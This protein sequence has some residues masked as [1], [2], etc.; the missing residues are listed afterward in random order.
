MTH[1]RDGKGGRALF[2]LAFSLVLSTSAAGQ[3]TQSFWG[4]V[5][6]LTAE[7]GFWD[8]PTKWDSGTLPL[9]QSLV[10]IKP[11]LELDDIV[12]TYRNTF[13]PGAKWES[14]EVAGAPGSSLTLA[15]YQTDFQ[16]R[17][18]WID[19]ATVDQ[20]AVDVNISE[21]V[22]D[23]TATFG[24]RYILRSGTLMTPID[25]QGHANGLRIDPSHDGG[26]VFD[27]RGGIADLPAF[28]VGGGGLYAQSGGLLSAPRLSI[29][30]NGEVELTGGR[31]NLYSELALY[32]GTAD[33]APDATDEALL[34]IS[35]DA[36]LNARF[37]SPKDDVLVG[38]DT[39]GRI[40]Q[41][42]NDSR[43]NY[44]ELRVGHTAAGSYLLSSGE[45]SAYA[46][47]V[48]SAA[49]GSITQTGGVFNVEEETSDPLFGAGLLALGDSVNGGP[50]NITGAYDLQGG[51]LNTVTTTVGRNTAGVFD[52]H[53]GTFHNTNA[54][55]I[56]NNSILNRP[57]SDG[58]YNLHGGT[59]VAGQTT[60]GRDGLGRFNHVNGAHS[61]LGELTIRG[62]YDFDD[63]N[64]NTTDTMLFDG[65]FNHHGGTHLVFDFLWADGRYTQTGGLL[66][67]AR[68]S[69]GEVDSGRFDQQGGTHEVIGELIVGNLLNGDGEYQLKPNA[70][71]KSD[72]L[73]V[74][75]DGTGLFHQTGGTHSTV[76]LVVGAMRDG[77]GAYTFDGGDLNVT[78]DADVGSNGTGVFNQN[79]DGVSISNHL[80]LGRNPGGEGTYNLSAGNL[81]VENLSVGVDGTGAFTAENGTQ[82]TVNQTLGVATNPNSAGTLTV[83]NV[84]L[85]TH[86]AHIAGRA[87]FGPTSA[88][89]VDA[90]IT[91]T[92][93]LNG[94]EPVGDRPGVLELDYGR[95][96]TKEVI[97]GDTD[98]GRLEN[99]FATHVSTGPIT[100]GKAAG[101]FGRYQLSFGSLT[102]PGTT[103]GDQG[104]G[105]FNHFGD[106]TV[107]GTLAIGADGAYDALSG[108][109]NAST[110]DNAGRYIAGGDHVIDG[111]AFDNSG[112]LDYQGSTMVG[113]EVYF[114]ASLNAPLHNT[115]TVNVSGEDGATIAAAVSNHGVFN[116]VN[117]HLVFQQPFVNA[118]AYISD[119]STNT[120]T[121]LTVH[122]AGYLQGGVG[123]VF[124]ITGDLNNFS[125]QSGDWRTTDA[126]LRFNS[127]AHAWIVAADDLGPTP[128][129]YVDN[130][131]WGALHLT[132]GAHV[133]LADAAGGDSGAVY[134]GVLMMEDGLSQLARIDTGMT[135]YYDPTQLDNAYLQGLTWPVTGGGVVRPIPEPASMMLVSVGLLFIAGRRRFPGHGTGARSPRARRGPENPQKPTK[136][137]VMADEH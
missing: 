54:L 6:T 88:S 43:A 67:T 57:P 58:T 80:R 107:N 68:A 17:D 98:F 110:I 16:S 126:T 38:V 19:N 62:A 31:T 90:E 84:V 24:S 12:V 87:H 32:V 77:T 37:V 21:V 133:D 5:G 95:L 116:V 122:P 65:T 25:P 44:A 119:P 18:I 1:K 22:I 127:A 14:V 61:V 13:N 96:D 70:I 8:D 10:F 11:T 81:A 115:G 106:H 35:G 121:D 120:F 78:G 101:A 118:G 73:T 51:T 15:I 125:E 39:P 103:V 56:G 83:K 111:N 59:L 42:G 2:A 137:D 112:T 49:D 108:R 131:A 135:I 89:A 27:Q 130:F 94:D 92:L 100:L 3:F 64:L 52:Q 102:T 33:D 34:D 50:Y 117:T 134:V 109:V 29:A 105:Y 76:T 85:S 53:P 30:G 28:E 60:V 7:S 75:G 69:I 82:V 104:S 99:R 20:S 63:G 129:G 86:D 136:I 40:R 72:A 93:I 26:D 47:I 71:L 46:V 113:T 74:G 36:E 91:G 55:I 9:D 48:G 132:S 45:V 41:F 128:L 123:D 124:E 79:A 23:G 66:R 114:Y 97:I 4:D